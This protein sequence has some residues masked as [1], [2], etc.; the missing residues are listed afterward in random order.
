MR[1]LILLIAAFSA[2]SFLSSCKKDEEPK[3]GGVV[4][5][6]GNDMSNAWKTAGVDA[7]TIYVKGTI[8][9]SSAT[10]V[11]YPQAPNCDQSNTIKH[12]DK[13]GTYY[14][15]IRNEDNK[16]LSSGSVEIKENTCYQLMLVP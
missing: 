1:K 3:N 8:A 6:W 10:N 14:Y 15:E 13:P 12:S 4:F 7:I 5:W 9:G 2:V 16:A 11:Y